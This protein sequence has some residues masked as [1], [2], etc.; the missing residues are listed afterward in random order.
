MNEI[1]AQTAFA[2]NDKNMSLRGATHV[3]TW[4]VV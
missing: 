4:V 2:H 1:T 3:D